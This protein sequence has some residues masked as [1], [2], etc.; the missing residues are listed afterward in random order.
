MYSIT[1]PPEKAL[2]LPKEWISVGS[3]DG[4]GVP[5]GQQVVCLK[6]VWLLDD[7]AYLQAPYWRWDEKEVWD[8]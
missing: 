4:E 8:I 6:E 1:P 3:T 7:E 5:N 2:E